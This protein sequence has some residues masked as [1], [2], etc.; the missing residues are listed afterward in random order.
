MGKKDETFIRVM[1]GLRSQTP[2]AAERIEDERKAKITRDYNRKNET[3]SRNI[4]LELEKQRKAD[5]HHRNA[6]KERRERK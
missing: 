4:Q 5:E 2:S 6:E 1:R 3:T